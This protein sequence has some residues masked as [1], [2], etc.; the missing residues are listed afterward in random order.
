MPGLPRGARESRRA[1]GRRVGLNRQP[2]EPLERL[3]EGDV[4]TGRPL[5]AEL[6][7]L[8]AGELALPET[9]LYANFVATPEGV[10]SI[11][12]MPGSNAFIADDDDADRVVMGLLR[13]HADAVLIGAGVL[14]ASPSSTWR[15]EGVYPPLAGQY[16]E[17]RVQLGLTPTPEVAVLTGSGSI[18]PAH[19]L[20]VSGALVLTSAAGAARLEGAVP[21]TTTVLAL[22][23]RRTL[24]V[25]VVLETLRDRGHRRI[26]SEAG[27]HTFGELL[28]ADLV[29]ELF[30]TTSPLLVGDAG[31]GS[32]FSL[33]EGSDLMPDGVRARLLSVRRHGSHLFTRYSLRT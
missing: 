14:R 2:A 22:G 23:D 4:P 1:R 31:P 29:D 13:A 27:P 3:F 26:L 5:P 19:P 18:D 24:D 17:L 7:R 11:P 16:A 25:G 21:D 10:V 12:T 32:R 15:P 28:R 33:V 6:S 20:L 8:Y 9:C 30:L